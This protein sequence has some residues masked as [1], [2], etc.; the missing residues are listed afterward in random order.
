MTDLLFATP[1]WLL[2]AIVIIGIT[3]FVSGNRRQHAGVRLAGVLVVLLAVALLL[4]SYFVETDK[5]KA[6]HDTR[7]VVAA[8]QDADW[9]KL[10]SLLD[11]HASLVT[12]LGTVYK[13]RDDLIQGAQAA[14]DRYALKSVTIRSL[15]ATQDQ[16]G[17]AVD[18]DVFSVQDATMDRPVPSSWRF[19]W[20]KSGD[21]WRLYRITCL[22]IGNED[23]RQIK[24]LIGK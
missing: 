3:L 1:W 24:V 11:P 7:E 6:S 13:N 14:A 22:K 20:E 10:K 2:G 12:V 4:L 9:S 16:A 8:V 15:D 17:I 23:A 5:E 18:L 19:D 21:D